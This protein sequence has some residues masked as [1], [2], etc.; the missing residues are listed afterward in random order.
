MDGC[1]VVGP[2]LTAAMET[3]KAIDYS[4]TKL[5]FPESLEGPLDKLR[6]ICQDLANPFFKL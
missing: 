5:A 1:W 4:R 3:R 2:S 6:E